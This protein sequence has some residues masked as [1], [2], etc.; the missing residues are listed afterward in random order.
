MRQHALGVLAQ[1]GRGLVRV[2]GGIIETNRI[3]HQAH[4]AGLCVHHVHPHPP[5]LYLGVCEHL[6]NAVD[7]TTGHA[8]PLERV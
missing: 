7:R 2:Q 1:L 5:M 8:L 3:A 6:L 4:L